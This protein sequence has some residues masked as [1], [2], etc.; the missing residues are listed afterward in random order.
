MNTWNALAAPAIDWLV[1]T[2][3]QAAV[4]A[5]MVVC[6]QVVFNKVLS[7]RWRYLLWFLVV[8]RLLVPSLPESSVSLYRYVPTSPIT[9]I[10]FDLVASPSVAAPLMTTSETPAVVPSNSAPPLPVSTPI[11][12]K[13]VLLAIWLI[14]F[15]A[16]AASL[17]ERNLRFR[18]RVLLDARPADET[19]RRLAES[20]ARD[21]GVKRN[22]VVIE[23]DLLE[24]P[25][26]VGLF[27]PKL[28]LPRKVSERLSTDE[29]TLIFRHELAHLKRGDLWVHFLVCLLQIVHWFNPVLWWAFGRMRHD[30]ELATDALALRSTLNAQQA[31]GETLV[32]LAAGSLPH[33]SLDPAIGILENHRRIRQRI[34]QI[35]RLKPNA[36]AWS[37]FG[38]AVLVVLGLLAL[39]KAPARAGTAPAAVVKDSAHQNAN[40]Q[41]DPNALRNA[42][43]L[44]RMKDVR[45]LLD[46]GYN[47]NAQDG[48]GLTPLCWAAYTRQEDICKYLIERGADITIRDKRGENAAWYAAFGA[49][50]PQTLKMLLDRHIDIGGSNSDGWPIMV[51]M[52]TCSFPRPNTIAFPGKIYTAEEI[53]EAHRE[54]REVVRMLARAG[55]DLNA[56]SPVGSPLTVAIQGGNDVI[57]EALIENGADVRALDGRGYSPLVVAVKGSLSLPTIQLL[58]EK[59]ANVNTTSVYV[60]DKPPL[61]PQSVLK[62]LLLYEASL[63]EPDP[64][65]AD[66]L[67]LLLAHG[68]HFT[69][70]I[71][72]AG[73]RWLTAAV[74]GDLGQLKAL[75]AQGMPLDMSDGDRWTALDTVLAAGHTTCADWLLKSGAKANSMTTDGHDALYF[76]IS[77]HNLDLIVRLLAAG[78]DAKSSPALALAASEGY[79]PVVQCL[80]DAGGDGKTI[81]I[82]DCIR[83]GYVDIARL[84]LEHG[85]NPDP[86]DNGEKR[87]NVYWALTY[88]QPEILKMIL[89]HGADPTVK[90]VY[91]ETP[92]NWAQ[93]YWPAMVPVIQDA[94]KKW[95]QRGTTDTSRPARATVSVTVTP[96]PPPGIKWV[97]IA[98]ETQNGNSPWRT[99]AD[100]TTLQAELRADRFI[101]RTVCRSESGQLYFSDCHNLQVTEAQISSGQPIQVAFVTA[102][103]AFDLKGQLDS[104][105]PRPIKNGLAVACVSTGMPA[106]NDHAWLMWSK[107]APIRP[108]GTFE[109]PNLPPPTAAIATDDDAGPLQLIVTC[110]GYV[111]KDPAAVQFEYATGSQTFAP[112]VA[113]P[114]TVAMEPTGSARVRVLDPNGKPV[115]NA[116]VQ[117][118]PNET[119]RSGSNL[120]WYSTMLGTTWDDEKQLFQEETPLVLGAGQ[121]PPYQHLQAKYQ[122]VTNSDGF[123][124]V[125]DL[126]SGLVPYTVEKT[127]Y[128]MPYRLRLTG[129]W[130]KYSQDAIVTMKPGVQVTTEIR[131][132]PKIAPIRIANSTSPDG[133]YV[134]SVES[135]RDSGYGGPGPQSIVV[136]DAKTGESKSATFLPE[137]QQNQE[138]LIT[139][140]DRLEVKWSQT[141]SFFIFA[142]WHTDH[143]DVLGVILSPQRSQLGLA[144]SNL[145]QGDNAK[146]LSCD[147][148]DPN[149]LHVKVQY[150]WEAKPSDFYWTMNHDGQFEGSPSPPTTK[151]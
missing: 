115:P 70:P 52:L 17:I 72:E 90:T 128:D 45:R 144:C 137:N 71:S 44:G 98:M 11:S 92:L 93:Q 89:D 121:L 140:S 148:I 66:V 64:F 24:T 145:T 26:V 76:A 35:A 39:T 130:T 108:D 106:P 18:R 138:D 42:V 88:H 127:P 6:V 132:I 102:L 12:P 133:K 86:H 135:S 63:G 37:G 13:G 21:M 40:G 27:A 134:I 103:P 120:L 28:L 62:S 79:L 10:H 129:S 85:A 9:P 111:S 125:G 81:S 29:L 46:Q 31:Y 143:F 41:N 22:L 43:A 97:K 49:G 34:E 96:V 91:D 68:A 107:S 61:P 65:F 23:T 149:T 55:A 48:Q 33:T 4:L 116:L 16:L 1:S 7:A 78:A 8:T 67:K 131:L 126:P 99:S 73:N 139:A 25:A 54:Q 142:V 80:I 112:P 141:S 124:N 51:N 150:K 74:T 53:A 94:I 101:L 146:V 82:Y 117:F 59:G 30:R 110:D 77:V 147:F 87:Y 20:V 19:K 47:I 122:A 113:D 123:A 60:Y 84:A 32:K 100:G 114:L 56:R 75:K 69:A 57:V 15:F 5:V 36:Y 95:D 151:A 105:V 118:S 104:S 50:C 2:S 3:W 14:G 119:F 58:L 38:A 136:R 109:I 83:G